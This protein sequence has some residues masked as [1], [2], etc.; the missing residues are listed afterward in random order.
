MCTSTLLLKLFRHKA[1]ADDELLACVAQPD[2]D[3]HSAERH[4]AIRQTDGW[5]LAHIG[6]LDD[7][8][9]VQMLGFNFT[10]GSAGVL[11]QAGITPP[12][13][14]LT[15]HLH[16]TEPGRREGVGAAPATAQAVA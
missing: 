14:L 3:R 10:D 16:L 5:H 13:D 11:S 6:S 7:A 12:R 4:A 9:L 1:W 2:A 15:G 8:A